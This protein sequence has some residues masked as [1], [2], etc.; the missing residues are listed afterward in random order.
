MYING[1]HQAHADLPVATR[2]RRDI[3]GKLLKAESS[4]KPEHTHFSDAFPPNSTDLECIKMGITTPRRIKFRHSL[5]C[6][7]VLVIFV[8]KTNSN[9]QRL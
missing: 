6:I 1:N 2:H 4:V 9:Y 3:T 5:R 7:D 8:Y